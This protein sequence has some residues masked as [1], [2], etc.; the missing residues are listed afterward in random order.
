[1]TKKLFY[2]FMILAIAVA[3]NNQQQN[4]ENAEAVEEESMDEIADLTVANF[5]EMAPDHAGK[6]IRIKG[7]VSHTCKHGGKR[8]F[9]IDEGTEESVKIE[10]GENIASFDAELEGNDV[11]V[12]GILT[13]LIVDEN[14]LNN[15]E[16]EVLEETGDEY[17]I[18]DG[19]HEGEDA[20]EAE[21][22]EDEDQVEGETE[23]DH[24]GTDLEQIEELR[25]TLKESG[26]DHLSF[27]SVECISYEIAPPPSAE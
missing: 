8:M 12:T 7:T 6:Q 10:A 22:S 23:E 5:T 13:E 17:K 26:K 21:I 24:H 16:N 19:N 11:I 18:H 3:C 14:Y 25:N 4:A 27:Y 2:L 20:E 9:I 1:M 15:W